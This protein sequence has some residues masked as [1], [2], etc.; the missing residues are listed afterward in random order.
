V[1]KINQTLHCPVPD[2]GN[3]GGKQSVW[4]FIQLLEDHIQRQQ[5]EGVSGDQEGG[6]GDERWS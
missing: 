4:G 5:T 6:R 2:S 1:H 3:D